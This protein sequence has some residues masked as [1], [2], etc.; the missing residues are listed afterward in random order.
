METKLAIF[1]QKEIRKIWISEAGDWYFS[2]VDIIE[3]LTEST[4]PRRYWAELKKKLK[5]EGSELFDK[6][7]QLKMKSSD[8]KY[9]LTDVGNTKTILRLIQSIPSKK[10]EPFKIW[11]AKV[12]DE[13]INEIYDPELAI[14]RAISTYRKKGYSEDWIKQRLKSIDIRKELT[15][16]WKDRGIKEGV[17]YAILTNEILKGWSDMTTNEYKDYKGLKKESLKDNMTNL[18]LV[19]NMLAE[20]STTEIIKEEDSNGFEEVKKAS[21]RGGGV[22]GIARKQLEKETRK[23]VI[24]KKNLLEEKKKLK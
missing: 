22:A 13:R 11:L 5:E 14:E 18:E 6:I 23:K 8:G 9:Y 19:F 20:A 3:V 21:K 10:A 15:G 2:I 7:E 4:Q 12:G 17:E 1:E 24:S 16:E